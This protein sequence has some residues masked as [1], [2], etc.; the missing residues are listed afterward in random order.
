LGYIFLSASGFATALILASPRFAAF[1]RT[2]S[3]PL[4]SRPNFF[5]ISLWLL[6]FGLAVF[7]E[8]NPLSGGFFS[9]WS[10]LLFP[11][12]YMHIVEPSGGLTPL[13][14]TETHLWDVLAWVIISALFGVLMRK[15]RFRYALL[16]APVIIV[17]IT[18]LFLL[19]S[20]VFGLEFWVWGFGLPRLVG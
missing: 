13:I 19:L 14:Q 15:V 4:L 17:A 12:S 9:H 8:Q 7:F 3:A 5:A 6:P 20:Q 11:L 10:R 1:A 16:L 2:T 18:Y